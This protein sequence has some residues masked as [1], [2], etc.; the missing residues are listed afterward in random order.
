MFA[1]QTNV[2]EYGSDVT[3]IAPSRNSGTFGQGLRAATKSDEV[4]EDG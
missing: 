4:V 3:S 1:N 2:L